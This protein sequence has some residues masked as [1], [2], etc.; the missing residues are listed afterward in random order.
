MISRYLKNVIDSVVELIKLTEED[1]EDIKNAK[2][3]QIYKRTKIKNDIIAVF[4]DQKHLLDK[5]LINLMSTSED[6]ELFEIL[7]DKQ[8]QSLEELKTKLEELQDINKR[9]AKFVVVVNE[10]YSSLFDKIFPTEMDNYQKVNPKSFSL[11]E[12]SV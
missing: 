3:E 7:N 9:Y 4:E 8:K 6:K 11:I 1:I 5:E 12:M 2:N 10:F